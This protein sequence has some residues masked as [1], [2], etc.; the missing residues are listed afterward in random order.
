VG[1]GWFGL[2]WVGLGCLYNGG[3][4]DEMNVIFERLWLPSIP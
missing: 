1:C 3:I 2:G 4:F